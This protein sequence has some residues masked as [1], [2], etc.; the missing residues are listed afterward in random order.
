M[1]TNHDPVQIGPWPLGQD[2]FHEDPSHAVFQSGGEVPARLISASNVDLTDEG[3]A[4]LRPGLVERV[5]AT[6]GLNGFSGAGLMLL[7]DGG[8]IKKI[9]PSDWSESSLVTGLGGDRVEFLEHAGQVWWTDGTTT[10][11]ITADGTAHNWGCSAAPAPTLGTTSGSLR[12]ARYFVAAYF[13]DTDGIE[14]A[15]GRAAGI[16]T[17]GSSA[18]TATLSSVDANAVSVR[19]F[20]TR[21][22]GKVLYFAKE[23]AVGSLPATINDT[24]VSE[25]SIKNQ[26]LSPPIAGDGLFSFR[27]QIIIFDGQFLY[28]SFGANCHLFEIADVVEGRP[29]NVLAGAGLST[30]FWTVCERGSFWTVGDMPESWQTWKRDDRRYAAGSLVLAGSQI[31]ELQIDEPVALFISE[32]GLMAGIPDGRLIGLT[33]ERM[34]LGVADKRASFAFLRSDGISRIVFSLT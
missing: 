21:P 5:T 33:Q 16:V 10:G 22:N 2:T 9:D 24:K 1:R 11:R 6:A 7:Q 31:P 18:I 14:H 32:D 20:V 28:P 23:V 12:A 17:T 25:E 13:V 8:V 19:F 3:W 26:F 29:S 34:R 4:A 30:G 27:G 15:A